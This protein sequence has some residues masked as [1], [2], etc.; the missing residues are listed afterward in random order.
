MSVE[1]ALARHVVYQRVVVRKK[2]VSTTKKMSPFEYPECGGHPASS[3]YNWV[4]T[5]YLGY[6]FAKLLRVTDEDMKQKSKS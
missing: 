4:L 2:E 6:H 5:D 3:S 1:T